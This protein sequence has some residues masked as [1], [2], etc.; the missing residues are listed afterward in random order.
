MFVH[1]YVAN[2]LQSEQEDHLFEVVKEIIC[3]V[4]SNK[5]QPWLDGIEGNKGMD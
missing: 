5:I 1:I 4:H 2:C 3:L